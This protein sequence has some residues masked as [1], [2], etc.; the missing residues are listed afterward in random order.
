MPAT[1][2]AYPSTHRWPVDGRVMARRSVLMSAL[3]IL[4]AAS[5]SD[6]PNNGCDNAACDRTCLDIG[7]LMGVCRDGECVCLG[8]PDADADAD[9][10][11][12]ADAN[13]DADVRPDVPA[14][15]VA[16][17]EAAAEVI[18]CPDGICQAGE[19]CETCPDDCACGGDTPFCVDDACVEC[20]HQGDCPAADGPPGNVCV[21]H[22][23]R[24]SSFVVG[25][26][27]GDAWDTCFLSSMNAPSIWYDA[28]DGRVFFIENIHE[29]TGG[30]AARHRES[31]LSYA[32]GDA[33]AAT[34]MTTSSWTSTIYMMHGI[35]E[36]GQPQ[37][38]VAGHQR[39]LTVSIGGRTVPVALRTS[40][41]R[42]YS[43][44]YVDDIVGIGL[45]YGPTNTA[46]IYLAYED[47]ADD[48]SEPPPLVRVTMNLATYRFASCERALAGA[49]PL[50]A[51]SV[52]DG[53]VWATGPTG[54]FRDGTV[55]AA[56]VDG[57]R[58][59][60][61]GH[62]GRVYGLTFGAADVFVATVDG[63][64]EPLVLPDGWVPVDLAVCGDE[65]V[66]LGRHGLA[67]RDLTATGADWR[68]I[69]VGNYAPFYE[70]A[71]SSTTGGPVFVVGE[72]T[73][74]DGGSRLV[75]VHAE[76]AS[77]P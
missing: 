56:D 28:V 2:F 63:V 33:A 54:L 36:A 55:A 57:V 39:D 64:E 35:H 43:G 17:D 5:C 34:E 47:H 72:K 25:H 26:V 4:G 23:C 19:G 29:C 21:D 68:E 8:A 24:P 74:P 41:W 15:D 51:V 75:L 53:S 62:D 7:A 12:D 14:E 49:V 16:A 44:S 22:A 38:W 45:T 18:T 46:D 6:E 52:V 27:T 60:R 42:L 32:P 58:L 77:L 40:C 10:P 9:A 48:G 61:H 65:L 20:L 66:V 73:L 50:E 31:I 67:V 76:L 70:L 30:S 1:R 11:A 13:D 37:L 59:S 71:C 69:G 3:A